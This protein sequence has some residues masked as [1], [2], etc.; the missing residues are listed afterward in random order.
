MVQGIDYCVRVQ[1]S[2]D[3]ESG[4]YDNITPEDLEA[5]LAANED[6]PYLPPH[7]SGPQGWGALHAPETPESRYW[8]RYQQWIEPSLQKNYCSAS[9]EY[10]QSPTSGSMAGIDGQLAGVTDGEEN[11]DDIDVEAVAAIFEDRIVEHQQSPIDVRRS[12]ARSE[13]FEYHQIRHKKGDYDITNPSV[14]K[15]IHPNKLRLTYPQDYDITIHD[16]GVGGPSADMPKGWGD[17]LPVTHVDIK[18]PSEHWLEGRQYAAEYQIFLVQNRESQRGA[19]AVSVLID[20]HPENKRNEKLQALLNQFQ[21]GWNADMAD[22]ENYVRQ[23]RRVLENFASFV[24]DEEEDAFQQNRDKLRRK[25]QWASTDSWDP[26]DE[27][28]IRSRYFFGYEG[29]I[30]EP[31]CTQFISWRVMELPALISKEQLMQM[32]SI[33]FNHVDGHCRPTSNHHDGSVARPL[34][35]FNHREMWQCTCRDFIGDDERKWYNRN[36]C[37]AGDEDIFHDRTDDGMYWMS[38][39]IFQPST[40]ESGTYNCDGDPSLTPPC[41]GETFNPFHGCCRRMEC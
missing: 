11:E 1:D 40:N 39:P 24:E 33:L 4:R 13:C 26:W 8:F 37:W 5:A 16:D 6:T 7:C 35:P 10:D 25:A 12:M 28:I 14:R 17:Q 15:E 36:R 3:Y 29:S 23:S 41:C 31:P 19:P 2:K 21:A 20:L 18:I 34:Q 30:T 9:V 32:K 27:D 38:K 22:C